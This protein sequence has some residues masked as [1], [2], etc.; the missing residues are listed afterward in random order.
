MIVFCYKSTQ[1]QSEPYLPQYLIFQNNADMEYRCR[2]YICVYIYIQRYFLFIKLYKPYNFYYLYNILLVDII[3]YSQFFLFSFLFIQMYR[4]HV[5]FC[6]LHRQLSDQVRA[7][8]VS[9]TQRM[10][11]VPIN[12]FLIIFPLSFSHS[13]ESPLSLHSLCPCEHISQHPLMSENM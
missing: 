6:Y 1:Q 10:Y 12:Q 13:S 5:I 11:T 7:F 4:V 3:N 8:R 2:I 9:F